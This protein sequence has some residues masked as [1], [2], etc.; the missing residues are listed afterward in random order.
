MLFCETHTQ[1]G[2]CKAFLG[3]ISVTKVIWYEKETYCLSECYFTTCCTCWFSL[4]GGIQWLDLPPYSISHVINSQLLYLSTQCKCD[5][6]FNVSSITLTL[7][8]LS[9]V[10]WR[11]CISR[12]LDV[13][14]VFDPY[15][16][17]L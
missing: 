2:T 14:Q 7:E 1:N 8:K 4:L 6:S 3:K 15:P 9:D 13:H 5:G 11:D 10:Y 12:W 17:Q 16:H